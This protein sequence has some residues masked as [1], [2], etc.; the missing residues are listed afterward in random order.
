M[1]NSKLAASIVYS[2]ALC[3]AKSDITLKKKLILKIRNI[4]SA[5]QFLPPSLLILN[6]I[7][8]NKKQF[9]LDH[10]FNIWEVKVGFL[11]FKK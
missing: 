4:L 11:F 2:Y 3:Q 7:V 9:E 6:I 10:A 8:L 1:E 5:F